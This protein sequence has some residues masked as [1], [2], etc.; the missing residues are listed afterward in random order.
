M[1]RLLSRLKKLECL[2]STAQETPQLVVLRDDDPE[3]PSDGRPQLVL[4][5]ARK[6]TEEA[7]VEDVQACTNS[8]G[9]LDTEAW[10]ARHPAYDRP[11]YHSEP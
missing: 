8:Q 10:V 4:R 7:W 5:V 6:M 2:R 3:P 11:E 1:S 9:L